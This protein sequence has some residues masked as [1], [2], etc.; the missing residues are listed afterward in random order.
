MSLAAP[1]TRFFAMAAIIEIIL[2]FSIPFSHCWLWFYSNRH[3]G[4]RRRVA[5]L[6]E[7]EMPM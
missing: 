3:E 1:I 6:E 7:T 5:V 4:R 2:P